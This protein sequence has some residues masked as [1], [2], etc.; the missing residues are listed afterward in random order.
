MPHHLQNIETLWCHFCMHLFTFLCRFL[1]TGGSY[2]SMSSSYWAH[3]STIVWIVRQ[4]C[5]ALWEQ[6]CQRLESKSGYRLQK[7]FSR[8]GSSQ[9]VLVP[10]MANIQVPP[11]FL[12]IFP[13]I[14]SP[15]KHTSTHTCIHHTYLPTYIHANIIH[16]HNFSLWDF[17][18]IQSVNATYQCIFCLTYLGF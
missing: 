13:P 14:Y 17:F 11:T 9:I 10:L 1:A 5:K 18:S 3:K 15:N 4:V 12:Y 6:L 2:K 16:T 7:D 8:E